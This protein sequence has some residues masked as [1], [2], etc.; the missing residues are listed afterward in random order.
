M[1]CRTVSVAGYLGMK[2]R[3]AWNARNRSLWPLSVLI[4]AEVEYFGCQVLR[5]S[6][7]GHGIVSLQAFSSADLQFGICLVC[8]VSRPSA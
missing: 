6:K 8:N 4:Q 1:L 2:L 3:V 5:L 7:E